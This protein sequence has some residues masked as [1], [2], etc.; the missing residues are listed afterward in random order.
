MSLEPLAGLRV[1]DLFA[2]SG[3][4]GIEALSRGA[5]HVDFVERHRPALAVL[6]DNLATL[7]LEDFRA[8]PPQADGFYAIGDIRRLKGDF[9]GAEAALREAHS[10]GRSPQPALALIRL[11]EGKVKAAA[12]A[13][14]AAL[15][16]QTWDRWA[17]SRLLPAQVEIA[18]AAGPQMNRPGS[19]MMRSP[20]GSRA[21]AAR[22]GSQNAS[23]G[24][25]GSR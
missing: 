11:A 13:I 23:I 17:R 14:G 12:V 21:I 10:R 9:E 2:G 1:V 18:I 20:F 6:R 8:V 24:G 16:D 19:A 15:A 5:E 22:I 3:A 7:E 4:L 25:A